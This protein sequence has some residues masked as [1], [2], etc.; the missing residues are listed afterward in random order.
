M[1]TPDPTRTRSYPQTYKGTEWAAILALLKRGLEVSGDDI[2]SRHVRPLIPDLE[3]M[4]EAMRELEVP[5]CGLD[6]PDW[7]P[8]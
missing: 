5:G 4:V 2:E 6:H 7:K 1:Q 8:E 3:K